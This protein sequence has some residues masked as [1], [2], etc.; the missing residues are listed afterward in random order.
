MKIDGNILATDMQDIHDL[1]LEKGIEI[2]NFKVD[3]KKGYVKLTTNVPVS[4]RQVKEIMKDKGKVDTVLNNIGHLVS[5]K[6][7]SNIRKMIASEK[8]QSL[9][10]DVITCGAVG[11]VAAVGVSLMTSEFSIGVATA[12]AIL[13]GVYILMDRNM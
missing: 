10:V 1:L 12:V 13:A 4:K 2:T 5:D 9:L 6:E 11:G 3:V 8:G 7:E